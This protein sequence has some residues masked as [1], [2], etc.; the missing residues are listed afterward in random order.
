MGT[1]KLY[2][3]GFAASIIL[4]LAAY[5]AVAAHILSGSMLIAAIMAL[6]IIQL[7]VQLIFFLHLGKGQDSTWNLVVFFST[8]TLVLIIVVGSLWIMNHLNYNMTPQDINNYMSS[9]DG[10]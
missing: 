7:I 9:Q 1:F 6:A 4:T 5:F 3:T 10:I 2:L 8:V